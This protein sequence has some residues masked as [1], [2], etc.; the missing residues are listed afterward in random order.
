MLIILKAFSRMY[1]IEPN[2]MELPLKRY[3]SLNSFFIRNLKTGSRTIDAKK[4]AIVS[5]VDG[6]VLSFGLLSAGD[7]IQSKGIPLKLREILNHHTLYPKFKKGIW[8]TIYLAP[9]NYHRVH[10]PVTGSVIARS[11]SPGRLLPVNE[12]AVNLVRDLFS[13]NERLTSYMKTEFGY[14]ALTKVGATNV[15]KIKLSYDTS[16]NT[17]G[18][19]RSPQN[20]EYEIPVPIKKGEELARFEMGSTVILFV[21]NDRAKWLN[22]KEKQNVQLGQSI[23]LFL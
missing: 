14:V 4:K 23:G 13:K 11:Y 22:L 2:E 19:F 6:K 17:N 10:S 18:W 21:E 15:G 5:P 3:T 20:H 9:Q 7:M 1:G 12:L 16:A 8:M